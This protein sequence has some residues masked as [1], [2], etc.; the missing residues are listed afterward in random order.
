MYIYI[1]C[2]VLFCLRLLR[3]R[4]TCLAGQ[5]RLGGERAAVVPAYIYK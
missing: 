3:L 2:A 5:A 1:T 4:Q